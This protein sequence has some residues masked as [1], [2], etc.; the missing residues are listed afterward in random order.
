MMKRET[1]RNCKHICIYGMGDYG[2]ETYFRLKKLGV[3]IDFFA[4]RNSEKRGYALEGVY[5]RSYEELLCEDKNN[6]F[7]IVAV[8]N[9]D[10]LIIEFKQQGFDEVYNK[11]TA[12]KILGNR[13]T[14]GETE[15]LRDIEK[16]E[17]M[18]NDIQA[19][20]YSHK[21]ICCPQIENIIF[22]YTLR[23]SIKI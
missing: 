21:G 6:C 16:I 9:P 5:C 8:K 19:L 14:G 22:D 2:L 23:H 13:M 10:R 17:Q 12:V 15:S 11:E 20:V 3:K 1:E 18:K 7:L 4:D